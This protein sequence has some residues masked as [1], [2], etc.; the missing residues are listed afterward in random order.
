LAAWR[1]KNIEKAKKGFRAKAQNTQ[2]RAKI[3]LTSASI[4]K[5]DH[6]I[7]ALTSP[8]QALIRYLKRQSQSVE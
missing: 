4:V 3:S 6:K 5:H 2:R 1:E 8:Y 7:T